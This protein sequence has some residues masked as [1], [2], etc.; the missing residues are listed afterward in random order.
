MK[1]NHEIIFKLTEEK[2]AIH[3]VNLELMDEYEELVL[4]NDKLKIEKE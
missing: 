2:N 4:R 1:E 3:N